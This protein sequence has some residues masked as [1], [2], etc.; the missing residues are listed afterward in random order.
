MRAWLVCVVASGC[1]LQ[2]TVFE[3]GAP[4]PLLADPPPA[5]PPA[6]VVGCITH[7]PG[8]RRRSSGK[9]WL[10]ERRASSDDIDRALAASPIA[11]PS[12]HRALADGRAM[13]AL[14]ITGMALAHG[15]IVSAIVWAGVD[16]HAGE[17]PLYLLAPAVA[18][19]GLIITGLVLD[20]RSARVRRQAIDAYND[21]AA[22]E[23]RCPP[24]G[25][26]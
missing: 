17:K 7:E 19:V 15:S 9:W 12:L 21:A 8:Y 1:Y 6:V 23:N 13:P 5:P 20:V 4:P 18:G 26:L 22:R 10:G 2:P 24:T 11:T 25:R 14:G 3:G 16:Q